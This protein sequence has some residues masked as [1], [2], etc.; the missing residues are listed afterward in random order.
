MVKIKRYKSWKEC[1]RIRTEACRCA[2]MVMAH[3]PEEPYAPALWSL[4]VFFESYIAK[5]SG[6]TLKDFG[7]KDPVKLAPVDRGKA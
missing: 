1:E 7:P 3:R 5:G 2:A 6:R 4:A